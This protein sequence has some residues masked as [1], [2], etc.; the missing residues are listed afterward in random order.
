MAHPVACCDRLH[1]PTQLDLSRIDPASFVNIDLPTR[2]AEDLPPP[3]PSSPRFS[4][5]QQ[6]LDA[7]DMSLDWP[8]G[9]GRWSTKLIYEKDHSIHSF[10]QSAPNKNLEL[11]NPRTEERSVLD[12]Q[13]ESCVSDI[14]ST[15]QVDSWSQ[16]RS[17]SSDS[18]TISND[19]GPFVMA[20]PSQHSQDLDDL[21][22][23]RSLEWPAY[24]T[25]SYPTD[26]TVSLP[27]SALMVESPTMLPATLR[28]QQ[29][30]FHLR[31]PSSSVMEHSDIG[32]PLLQSSA[33]HSDSQPWTP[34][35]PADPDINERS[36]MDFDDS[37]SEIRDKPASK[38][39]SLSR[40]FD[41]K[42]KG[43]RRRGFGRSFSD[44]FSS[45][46]CTK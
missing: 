42:R 43:H 39:S 37:E 6:G 23:I 22:N 30:S 15:T 8:L 5:G 35:N 13:S 3:P 2:R 18:E 45:F 25:F 24:T 10:Y 16:G 7:S 41:Q 29:P 11:H 36:F 28:R 40:L 44:V 33:S 38:A 1:K 46:S 34:L 17:A 27:S 12:F 31:K 14:N 9:Q 20:T 4:T 21:S 26:H 32:S 19:K